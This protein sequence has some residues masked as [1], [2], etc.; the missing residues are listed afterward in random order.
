MVWTRAT[1]R[2]IEG[3][4]RRIRTDFRGDRRG[5]WRWARST[6]IKVGW[7]S[8]YQLQE[9]INSTLHLRLIT[10]YDCKVDLKWQGKALDGT[11]VKGKLKIPEVSHEI[12][13]DGLSDYVVRTLWTFASRNS[14]VHSIT[15]LYQRHHRLPL[16]NYTHL[17]RNSYP[18][19]L[20]RSLRSSRL[21]SSRHMERTY[22]LALLLRHLERVLLLR[23]R[24]PRLP[25]Q[26]QLPWRLLSKRR[27][28]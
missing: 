27:R 7:R 6:E 26:S 2:R 10:I 9:T 18:R 20:K 21:L 4:R 3:W 23:L 8:W 12:T 24:P 25:Q 11:E 19:C 15:G 28:C 13:L 5:R 1:H 16:T 14:T 22:K 17:L